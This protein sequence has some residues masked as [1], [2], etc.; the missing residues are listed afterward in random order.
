MSFSDDLASIGLYSS[1]VAQV[2]AATKRIIPSTL[3]IEKGSK[4]GR[5]RISFEAGEV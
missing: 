1:A 3:T 2:E 5:L 4:R